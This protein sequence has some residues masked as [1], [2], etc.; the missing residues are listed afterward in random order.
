MI[1]ILFLRL[2]IPTNDRQLEKS[3]LLLKHRTYENGRR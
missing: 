2:S 3:A 1:K